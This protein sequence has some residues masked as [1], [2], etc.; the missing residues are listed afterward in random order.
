M[1]RRAGHITARGE[2]KW[3]VRWYA[4]TDA[5]GKRRYSAKTVHGTKRDAQK[6]L[7]SVPRSQ[8][9]GQYLEPTRMTIDAYL[10]Q[11]LEKSRTRSWGRVGRAAQYLG[12]L[13]DRPELAMRRAH[14]T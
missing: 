5:G 7:N 6:Y 8:D 11:W 4:G 13:A 14:A 10:D 9:L 12:D 2:R 3:L 1:A